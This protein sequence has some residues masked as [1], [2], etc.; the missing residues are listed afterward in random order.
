MFLKFTSY[1]L[2]PNT[3]VSVSLLNGTFAGSENAM[4]RD[5]MMD[6]SVVGEGGG[7]SHPV[8]TSWR[9]EGPTSILSFETGEAGTYVVGVSTR[10]NMIEL[11]AEEFSEYLTH[12]GVLD[13][14][15]D[16]HRNQITDHPAN[17][18][19]SKHVKA[20]FQVGMERTEDFQ[21]V[22]GYPVEFVLLD[23][24]YTLRTGDRLRVRFLR[25]GQPVPGQLVYASYESWELSR[26]PH[27]ARE[28]VSTFTDEEGIA[29]ITL[30]AAG[31]WYIRT[32]HMLPSA[33]VGVD[34]VSEWATVTFEIQ[35]Q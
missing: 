20:V 5:R 16:R 3:L 2:Q 34:Y 26:G 22:L 23:N 35:N 21:A 29:H 28:A 10:P 18:R 27:G 12:D 30:Q 11:T 15:R 9:D 17:E 7:K 8:A 6:V 19:Y 14:L 24:P 33:E 13:I 25:N 4:A 1:F 32:I 31:R